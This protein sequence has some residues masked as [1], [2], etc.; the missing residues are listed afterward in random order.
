MTLLGTRYGCE[1][2]YKRVEVY[3]TTC[4]SL[5]VVL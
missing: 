2:M 3:Q 4:I 1:R 5:Y